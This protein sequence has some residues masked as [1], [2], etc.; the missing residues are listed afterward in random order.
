MAREYIAGANAIDI[1]GSIEAAVH[2]GRLRPGEALPTVRAL[3]ERLRVS[4]ATV[5]GA[6]KLLSGRGLVSGLGRRGTRVTARPPSPAARSV[7]PVPQGSVD[8]ATGNPDPA[9]LPPLDQALRSIDPA[10]RFYGTS[11]Q[12]PALTA[13]AAAEFEADGIPA[14]TTTVVAGGLDGIERILREHVRPG[15]RVGVED[16]SYPGVLDLLSASGLVPTPFEI[17]DEGPVPE[18]IEHALAGRARAVIVTPRAQNPTGAALTPQRAAELRRVLRRYAEVLLIE[19]DHAGP[20]AGAPAQTLCE[21]ARGRW[22]VVRSVSKFLGP[23]LRVALV[24]G[25]GLT[26][27]RVEGRLA[28]GMRWVSHILQQLVIAL[29]SD[30]SSGRRLARAA[31]IYSLRR[32][33]LLASLAS[34]G[35]PARGRSGLNVWIPVREEARVVQMLLERGWAVTAGERFR[36]QTPPAIRVTTAALGPDDAERFAA[37]LADVMQPSTAAIA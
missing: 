36:L 32:E 34:R 2:E 20:V 15:D 33:A 19:D 4:P 3:A 25:D 22:A 11:P 37:D 29:W 21:A 35:I 6:Y 31:D 12:M 9:L 1:A 5:A 8:L 30:P 23:D 26:I 28:L 18:S 13:F 17:D 7:A 10:P 24:A 14:A 16:P 27:A